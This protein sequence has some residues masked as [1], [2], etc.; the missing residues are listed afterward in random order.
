MRT[1]TGGFR[2]VCGRRL[3]RATLRRETSRITAVPSPLPYGVLCRDLPT[4]AGDRLNQPIGRDPFLQ[5]MEAAVED[6]VERVMASQLDERDEH[7]CAENH[8]HGGTRASRDA[9]VSR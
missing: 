9:F 3:S 6:P 2:R 1:R 4:R 7:T 8:E 5:R